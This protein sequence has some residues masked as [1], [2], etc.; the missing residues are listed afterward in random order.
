[1]CSSDL[2]HERGPTLPAEKGHRRWYTVATI[3]YQRLWPFSAG[4]VGPRSWACFPVPLSP[5]VPLTIWIETSADTAA[6]AFTTDG[7]AWQLTLGPDGRPLSGPVPLAV[8]CQPSLL[9][10]PN[11]I[12]F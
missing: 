11:A 12:R 3:V 10:R 8:R 1:M 7:H 5:G 2:A 6:I 4:S 9:D